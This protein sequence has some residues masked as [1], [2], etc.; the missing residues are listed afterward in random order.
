MYSYSFLCLQAYISL[1]RRNPTLQ[2]EMKKV[3]NNKEEKAG[4]YRV[5]GIGYEV[6]KAGEMKT[7][8]QHWNKPK[9]DYCHLQCDTK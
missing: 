3:K 9:Q 8:T 5:N 6:E 2:E 1:L 7:T 4:E